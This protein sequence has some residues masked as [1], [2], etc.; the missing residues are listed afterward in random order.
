MLA[1]FLGDKFLSLPYNIKSKP[2][3]KI[4]SKDDK[5]S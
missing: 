1:V 5:Y 3:S 2:N 4:Y